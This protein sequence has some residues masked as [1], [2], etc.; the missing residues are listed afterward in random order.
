[1]VRPSSA[2]QV[3]GLWSWE[4]MA[5]LR[6][7]ALDKPTPLVWTALASPAQ[8]FANIQEPEQIDIIAKGLREKQPLACYVALL[9]TSW[10]HS[11]PLLCSHG[12]SQLHILHCFYKYEALLA[13]L[14]HTM[15]LFL[16]AQDS[17][18]SCER[19]VLKNFI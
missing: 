15:P 11:L 9:A 12:F 19:L 5:R 18:L 10:G 13:V 6:L 7:H 14:Q 2:E 17:L 3:F 4:I 1:M 16:D 8:A